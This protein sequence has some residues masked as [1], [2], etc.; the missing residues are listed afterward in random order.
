VNVVEGI[1]DDLRHG[2]VPNLIAEKG[3][4]AEWKYNRKGVI[5]KAA[6]GAAIGAAVI[7]VLVLRNRTSKQQRLPTI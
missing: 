7:T 6:I 5:Q 2:I 4:T 1:V 3:W